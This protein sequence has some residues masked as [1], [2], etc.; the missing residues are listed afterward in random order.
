[1]PIFLVTGAP[2]HG[3]TQ[4]SLYH[5]MKEFNATEPKREVYYHGIPDLNLPWTKLDD[6]KELDAVPDGAII[7]LDE[8]QKVYRTRGTGS[9]VPAHVSYLETHRHRGHDLFL[10]TQ[11]PLLIDGNVR[12][13]VDTHYHVQRPF[14]MER[15]YVHRFPQV[16]ERPDRQRAGS[17]KTAWK[18]SSEVQSWYK[19]AEVHT[20]KRSIPGR[21]W[22]LLSVPVILFVLGYV[23]TI[24]LDKV[25]TGGKGKPAEAVE[26]R[27]ASASAAPPKPPGGFPTD[28]LALHQP[29]IEGL[30][31]TAPVYDVVNQVAVAPKPS[32]CVA[33]AHRCVCYTVQATRLD[34]PDSICRDIARNGYFDPS[35][36]PSPAQAPALPAPAPAPAPASV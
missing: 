28:V 3:K 25:A 33:S 35:L 9:A 20:V 13:L 32:A 36:M 19:S 12:R 14:G 10:I 4:W 8:C 34:V 5:L 30:A 21:V 7:V 6:P 29:R 11:H 27:P 24:Y 31:Y 15:T 17:I 18:F 22:F 23:A 16:N 2:G 1:M 26:L